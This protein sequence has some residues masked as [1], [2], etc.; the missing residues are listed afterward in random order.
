MLSYYIHIIFLSNCDL[1]CV[2]H[3]VTTIVFCI[4][5]QICC[6]TLSTPFNIYELSLFYFKLGY[7]LEWLLLLLHDSLFQWLNTCFVILTWFGM[8]VFHFQ[9]PSNFFHMLNAYKLSLP[10]LS[11]VYAMVWRITFLFLCDLVYHTILL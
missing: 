5:C 4:L 3:T 8:F 1:V 7:W 9:Y 6:Y 2:C 11:V 10:F